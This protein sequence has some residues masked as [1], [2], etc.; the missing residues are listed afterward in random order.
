[1][2][3]LAKDK[4]G[5]VTENE[6]KYILELLPEEKLMTVV[7]LKNDRLLPII[8]EIIKKRSCKNF[9]QLSNKVDAKNV[10]SP[11]SVELLKLFGN[12]IKRLELVYDDQCP[13]FDQ[14]I[15]KAIFDYCSESLER[16]RLSNVGRFP[17]FAIDQQLKNVTEV[18]IKS[19]TISSPFLNFRK[20]FP[21]LKNLRLIDI[22][23]HTTQDDRIFKQEH[24]YCHES[25]TIENIRSL[26][27]SNDYMKEISALVRNCPKLQKCSIRDQ[28]N[29][30]KLLKSIAE[31]SPELPNLR[32]SV[33][34]DKPVGN[35]VIHFQS[36]H[37]LYFEGLQTDVL[38][39]YT[40]RIECIEYGLI[41]CGLDSGINKNALQL[42]ERNENVREVEISQHWANNEAASTFIRLAKTLPELRKVRVRTFTTNQIVDMLSGCETLKEISFYWKDTSEPLDYHK[43]VFKSFSDLWIWNE[44]NFEDG[45]YFQLRR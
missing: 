32:L 1:M 37:S 39:I 23:L 3:G 26:N 38:N 20:L 11:W 14:T 41:L 8:R 4:D 29:V 13:K 9:I 19:G 12:E 10:N 42:L 22:L 5:M 24:L 45:E 44:G 18:E 21:K 15:E 27:D 33:H 6:M 2:S 43:T 7:N 36:L 25:L 40:D 35:E 34:F 17:M 16:I 30:D 28:D 31:L